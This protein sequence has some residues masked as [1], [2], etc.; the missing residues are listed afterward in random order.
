MVSLPGT[1]IVFLE[2]TLYLGIW[3]LRA[4]SSHHERSEGVQAQWKQTKNDEVSG[5][6][7]NT[8]RMRTYMYMCVCFCGSAVHTCIPCDVFWTP[9]VSAD[10]LAPC[11]SMVYT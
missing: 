11:A 3:T 2:Y 10:P 1:V 9:A 4:W 7:S 6:F 8:T 5:N